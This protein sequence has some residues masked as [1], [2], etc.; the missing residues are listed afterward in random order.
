MPGKAGATDGSA[1]RD[2]GIGGTRDD[3]TVHAMTAIGTEH[4]RDDTH[5]DAA[6]VRIALDPEDLASLDVL[7]RQIARLVD[8]VNASE[9][10]VDVRRCGAVL[11]VR[12]VEYANDGLWM[13]HVWRD[14]PDGATVMFIAGRGIEVRAP[15][16]GRKATG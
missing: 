10:V 3:D 11:Q 6:P 9:W 14:V 7:P 16:S 2:R 4:A 15:G 13:P 12:A 1:F 5:V 8:A